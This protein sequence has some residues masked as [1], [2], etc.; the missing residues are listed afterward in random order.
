MQPKD[1][2]W[3]IVASVDYGNWL[4]SIGFILGLP[5]F[6]IAAWI[7]LRKI[8]CG[9]VV[10]NYLR[11]RVSIA[12]LFSL[13]LMLLPPFIIAM[14]GR[15]QNAFGLGNGYLPVYL[16]SFGL[17]LFI[18]FVFQWLLCKFDGAVFRLFAAVILG[19]LISGNYSNNLSVAKALDKAWRPQYIFAE[20]LHNSSFRES[21]LGRTFVVQQLAPWTDWTLMRSISR[22]GFKGAEVGKITESVT[23]KNE[24][25]EYCVASP[26]IWQGRQGYLFGVFRSGGEMPA[27]NSSGISFFYPVEAGEDI[28]EISLNMGCGPEGILMRRV[29]RQHGRWTDYVVFKDILHNKEIWRAQA[30][31]SLECAKN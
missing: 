27:F 17:A 10:S 4:A 29:Y 28:V 23:N 13:G 19:V 20:L 9:C 11:G 14:V 15:Y 22:A 31:I 16:Q 12:L 21:C 26:L 3:G 1:G 18:A 7:A 5:V 30:G 6:V 2:N 24:I 8:N 25:V